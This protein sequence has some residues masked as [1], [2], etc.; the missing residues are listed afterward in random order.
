MGQATVDSSLSRPRQC[1]EVLRQASLRGG[2]RFRPGGDQTVK[3]GR[4]EHR[5][6]LT[7]SD[8]HLPEPRVLQRPRLRRLTA[9]AM[10]VTTSPLVG[11]HESCVHEGPAEM[12]PLSGREGR[13]ASVPKHQS[14]TKNLKFWGS[15]ARNHRDLVTCSP[16]SDLFT[17]TYC[18]APRP[19]VMGQ[20]R[21]A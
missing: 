10:V 18:V 13:L 12:L 6:Q 1:H 5:A 11:F 16:I 17:K 2:D 3:D 19:T 20:N 21:E 9:R 7:G 15:A 8:G 14:Q 4:S